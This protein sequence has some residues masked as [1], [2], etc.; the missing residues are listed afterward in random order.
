MCTFAV[1]EAI[2]EVAAGID[3][4]EEEGASIGNVEHESKQDSVCLTQPNDGVLPELEQQLDDHKVL[5]DMV[6]TLCTPAQNE[7]V[8]KSLATRIA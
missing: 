8:Y 6:R 7:S 1:T 3:D 2:P 5:G 4:T